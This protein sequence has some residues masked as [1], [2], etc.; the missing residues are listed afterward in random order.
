MQYASSSYL[1][2]HKTLGPGFKSNVEARI[3]TSKLKDY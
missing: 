1:D 3:S 2:K